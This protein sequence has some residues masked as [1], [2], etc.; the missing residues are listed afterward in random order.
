M[1]FPG[2]EAESAEETGDVG[3]V[4]LLQAGL[5]KDAVVHQPFQAEHAGDVG[6]GFFEAGVGGADGF[7]DIHLLASGAGEGGAK[8]VRDFMQ[9]G[10]G[11]VA[12]A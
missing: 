8:L 11:K 12:V 2:A 5:R 4:I 1:G 10:A 6:L 7:I 9:E 3:G